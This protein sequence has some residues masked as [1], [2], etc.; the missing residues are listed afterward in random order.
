MALQI[1]EHQHNNP[2]SVNPYCLIGGPNLDSRNSTARLCVCL[3]RVDITWGKVSLPRGPSLSQQP[4]LP[5]H[6]SGV[7]YFTVHVWFSVFLTVCSFHFFSVFFRNLL[8][9][10]ACR[11]AHTT[12]INMLNVRMKFHR[13]EPF[14]TPLGVL[15]PKA[16]ECSRS[17]IQAIQA[18]TWSAIRS[19]VL[20]SC[21]QVVGSKDWSWPCLTVWTIWAINTTPIAQV[22]TSIGLKHSEAVSLSRCDFAIQWLQ[23]LEEPIS[24]LWIFPGSPPSDIAVSG[25][26][27]GSYGCEPKTALYGIVQQAGQL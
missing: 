26:Q 19:V 21:C 27:W 13:F 23:A 22:C 1:R 24:N 4:S 5:S 9:K 3:S 11:N 18:C 25:M 2:Q 16:E 17:S 10:W 8:G 20:H 14:C 7:A 6:W 12:W 15:G